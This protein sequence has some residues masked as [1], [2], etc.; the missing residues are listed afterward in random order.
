MRTAS[1]TAAMIVIGAFPEDD[2]Q[3]HGKANRQP[4]PTSETAGG[5]PNIAQC[6]ADVHVC[7]LLRQNITYCDLHHFGPQ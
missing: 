6:V 2:Q 7:P 5:A 1:T 3:H 4:V